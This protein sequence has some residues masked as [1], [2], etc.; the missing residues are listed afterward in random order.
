MSL[1]SHVAFFVVF[2][3]ST[4][5]ERLMLEPSEHIHAIGIE[6]Y[7]KQ[8]YQAYGGSA[9]H[10][11]FAY[12]LAGDHLVEQE[13]Y[14]PTIKARYG[15]EVHKGQYDG[16]ECREHQELPHIEVGREYLTETADTAHTLADL[17]LVTEQLELPYVIAKLLEG[18]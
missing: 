1:V 7:G 10:Y 8:Y 4:K 15:Q 18:K 11:F 6:H 12:L 5:Y 9:L 16:D 2:V 14:I 3:V 17:Y 13:H